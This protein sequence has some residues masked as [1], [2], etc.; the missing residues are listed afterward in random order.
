M[1]QPN[2]LQNY[3][4]LAENE[5]NETKKKHFL[6][7][8]LQ[9]AH[10]ASD[11]A[12]ILIELLPLV[13]MDGD[14]S[15]GK[16]YAE[17]LLSVGCD[18]AQAYYF[19]GLMEDDLGH[20]DAAKDLYYRSMEEEK[21]FTLA[22]FALGFLHDRLGEEDLAL[23]HYISYV[24]GL[25]EYETEDASVFNDIASIYIEQR[26]YALARRYLEE[27]LALDENYFRSWYNFGVL[28]TRER[29]DDSALSYYDRA[30]ELCPVFMNSYL[31]ESAIYIAQGNF[32]RAVEILNRGLEKLPDSVDLLYNR[33]C[34]YARLGEAEAAMSDLLRAFRLDREVRDYAMR[35]RDFETMNLDD[36][37]DEP[38]EDNEK[39]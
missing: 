30:I 13:Y 4:L 33:A 16:A 5:E 9:F 7:K 6:N 17:E 28:A 18:C 37:F 24:E 3:L 14:F 29:D 10:T 39:E 2:R 34:S 22:H 32:H 19:M 25:E 1:N 35:D 8:A 26:E 31:N 21:D 11:R 23:R 36:L 27:S 20:Y 12:D 15:R 38:D